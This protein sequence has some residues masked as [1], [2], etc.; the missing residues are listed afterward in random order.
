MVFGRIVYYKTTEHYFQSQKFIDP[1]IQ[2]NIIDCNTPKEASTIG[3]DRN[4]PIR[5]DWDTIRVQIMYDAV[6]EKFKQNPEICK[7][8]IATGDAYIIEETTKE[9]FW[10][11]GPDY[12]GQNTYGKIL[13]EVR[14]QLRN[15]VI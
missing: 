8:L 9:N 1:S 14:K 11:C 3:R 13:C 7:K 5:E 12:N 2:H 15:E 6:Y 10:G 4:L